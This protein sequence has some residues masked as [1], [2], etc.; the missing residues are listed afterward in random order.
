M[1]HHQNNG[2]CRIPSP[3]EMEA[4]ATQL[5]TAE[6][7]LIVTPPPTTREARLKIAWDLKVIEMEKEKALKT[8]RERG[9]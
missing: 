3:N 4:V 1:K 8:K 6:Q 9:N 2:K 7:D 5:L